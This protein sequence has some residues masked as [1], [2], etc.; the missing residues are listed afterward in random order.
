[1]AATDR[2]R[3][4]WAAFGC[5]AAVGLV[6][7]MWRG[8]ANS[9]F[10]DDWS[11]IEFR[12]T[13]VHAMLASYNQHLVIAPVAVYQAL[14]AMVGLTHYWPYRLLAAIG[15]LACA[16][17]VFAFA[18]RRVG[19][20]A[21]LLVAPIVFL[22]AGW[23]SVFQPFNAG[24]TASLACGI[25][26]LLALD[27]GDR[28]GERLACAALVAGLLCGE[29][30]ALF[31][32]GIALE[33]T[34]RDRSL[35]R[36]WIWALPIGLYIVWWITEYTPYL[37][38]HDLSL[39]PKFVAN[40]AFAAAGGLFGRNLETGR[41]VLLAVAAFV[42][43]RV[44]RHRALSPRLVAL[45]AILGAFWLLVAFTRAALGQ[46]YASRYVYSGVALL[47]LIIAESARGARLAGP[48]LAIAGI[49]GALAL[50]GNISAFDGAM[51][52]LRTGSR[53]VTAELG[54][55][56]LARD[57]VPSTFVLDPHWAP[58]VI[59]G[60][61]FTA[62]RAIGSTSADTPAELRRAPPPIRAA[63]YSVLVRAGASAAATRFPR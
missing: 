31:A 7:I 38:H 44:W 2:S 27:R 45:V 12:R 24:I 30:A 47:V 3:L 58:Q 1:L 33:L 19:D 61:Y 29:F 16:T 42:G 22:G 6:F 60:P 39:V 37:S 36:A 25:A 40:M 56:E 13:G 52:Y 54:A 48:T 32:A 21:L 8:R 62:V 15:H 50:I 59:A 43:W 11:W 35:R 9:F 28:R 26:A 53:T 5:L 55:L 63:A 34:W 10:F 4:S 51:D 41:F 57:V 18:R 49:V 14:L 20:A 46:P 17:A 23:E